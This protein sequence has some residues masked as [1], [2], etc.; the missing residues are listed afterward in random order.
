M[1]IYDSFDHHCFATRPSISIITATLDAG[2][3]LRRTRD[4]I[5]EQSRHAA[6]WIIKDG[7][8]CD[9]SVDSI[10]APPHTEMRIQRSLDRGIFDAL[11]QAIH[12]ARGDYVHV[13]A[14]GDTF[15]APTALE[16]IVSELQTARLPDL[17]YCAARHEPSGTIWTHPPRL[18]RWFLF[19]GGIC[20]QAQFWSRRALIDAGGFDP[21]FHLAADREFLV[22]VCSETSLR[23]RRMQE[24]LINYAGDGVSEAPW[25]TARLEEELSL[26]R[27]HH[28]GERERRWFA[29]LGRATLPRLR[30]QWNDRA[31]QSAGALVYRAVR[32][33]VRRYI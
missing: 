6:E 8:S 15:A 29:F 2:P 19:R 17:L 5:A 30:T 32:S 1:N 3:A 10:Q 26:I 22:R 21:A 27:Q 7:G 13:L 33:W 24:T 25:N 31:P 11:N 4:S 18:S 14:A 9:G 20:H 28:F 12:L 23:H 16:K